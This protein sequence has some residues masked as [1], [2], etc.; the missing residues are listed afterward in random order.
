M[1]LLL[2]VFSFA[3]GA[4]AAALGPAPLAGAA[5]IEAVADT[6]RAKPPAKPLTPQTG[7]GKPAP[8]ADRGKAAP[9]PQPTGDPKLKR[10]KPPQLNSVRIR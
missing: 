4:P 5:P 7:R 1:T 3:L 9:A 6:G 10:R 8:T 2:A